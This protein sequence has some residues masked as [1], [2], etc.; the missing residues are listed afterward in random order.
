MLARGLP[1]HYNGFCNDQV[2]R[3]I[4]GTIIFYYEFLNDAPRSRLRHGP[5][6]RKE[7]SAS[8]F[9]LQKGAF[10]PKSAFFYPPAAFYPFCYRARR[11]DKQGST[12]ESVLAFF[13]SC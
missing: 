11:S 7:G 13:G 12:L 9:S 3:V 8:T 2:T 5:M 4:I 6:L 10:F 1:P